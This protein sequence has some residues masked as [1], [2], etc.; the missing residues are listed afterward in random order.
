M[1]PKAPVYPAYQDKSESI[2]VLNAATETT[3]ASPVSMSSAAEA[4]MQ[5]RSENQPPAAAA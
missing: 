4:G 1:A 3:L 2:K 5:R